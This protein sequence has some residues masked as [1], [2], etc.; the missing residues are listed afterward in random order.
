M[1]HGGALIR[2]ALR[3]C[4]ANYSSALIRVAYMCLPIPRAHVKVPLDIVL[5]GSL[6][7]VLLAKETGVP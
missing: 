2:V 5:G 1:R 6:H 3:G 4:G 7:Y